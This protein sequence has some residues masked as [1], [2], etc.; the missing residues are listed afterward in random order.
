MTPKTIKRRKKIMS[1]DEY[2]EL[3]GR[4]SQYDELPDGAWWAACESE[5]G[6]YNKFMAYLEASKIYDTGA[7]NV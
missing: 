1:R 6:S 2:F 7:L 3:A 5:C 4:L